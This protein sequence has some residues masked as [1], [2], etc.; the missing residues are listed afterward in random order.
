MRNSVV[1]LGRFREGGCV[2]GALQRWFRLRLAGFEG[3]GIHCRVDSFGGFFVG[4]GGANLNRVGRRFG[5]LVLLW[6]LRRLRVRR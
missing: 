2:D 3:I 4:R 6:R 1:R 5:V